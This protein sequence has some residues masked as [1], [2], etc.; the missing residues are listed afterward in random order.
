MPSHQSIL[1][2]KAA[3]IILCFFPEHIFDRL[4]KLNGAST[5][6][7]LERHTI[8]TIFQKVSVTSIKIQSDLVSVR[9]RTTMNRIS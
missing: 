9:K 5:K 1:S 7:G 2:R 6:K 8:H 4:K 3:V